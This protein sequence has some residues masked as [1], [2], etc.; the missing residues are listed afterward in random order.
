MKIVNAMSLAKDSVSIADYKKI[1]APSKEDQR[2]LMNGLTV[3][4]AQWSMKSLIKQHPL[5]RWYVEAALV[6]G[7][8][9]EPFA[10]ALSAKTIGMNIKLK[11][12]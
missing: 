6:R 12:E 9:K 5:I 3:M 8:V 10:A 1:A 4:A 11:K 2:K 7:E